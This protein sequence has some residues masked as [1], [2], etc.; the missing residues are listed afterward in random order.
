MK[1]KKQEPWF[2][3]K[4]WETLTEEERQIQSLREEFYQLAVH[5]VLKSG[6]PTVSASMIQR[7]YVPMH[8]GNWKMS[9][10]YEAA[11][12]VLER[13][14]KENI[15]HKVTKSVEDVPDFYF[16]EVVKKRAPFKLSTSLQKVLR[17]IQEKE[18]K[19]ALPGKLL[20]EAILSWVKD[21]TGQS[22]IES[23]FRVKFVDFEGNC[24][25]YELYQHN[26]VIASKTFDV[27]ELLKQR[28]LA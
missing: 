16:Y 8:V 11:K 18:L 20:H 3:T 19:Q 5:Y 1:K 15:L 17:A 24:Y 26:E 2:T 13:M 25:A 6:T 23:P 22:T 21:V 10:N 14:V 28:K 7:L 9:P 4:A 27:N 12:E